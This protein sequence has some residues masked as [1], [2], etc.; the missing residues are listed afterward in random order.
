MTEFR[1]KL[2]HIYCEYRKIY[3]DL[4]HDKISFDEAFLCAKKLYYRAK[5]LYKQYNRPL[6]IYH[7]F[8]DKYDNDF[9]DIYYIS[10]VDSINTTFLAKKLE[11]FE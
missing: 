2:F 11:R 5:E 3:I 6:P 7:T 1:D 8:F 10:M 4:Q 9:D